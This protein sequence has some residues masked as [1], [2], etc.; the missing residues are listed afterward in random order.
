[1][2]KCINERKSKDL[3]EFMMDLIKGKNS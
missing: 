1:M 3:D 2:E